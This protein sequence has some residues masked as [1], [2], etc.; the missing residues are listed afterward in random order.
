MNECQT[1]F[2]QIKELEIYSHFMQ[3]KINLKFMIIVA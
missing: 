3:K 1:H 2:E